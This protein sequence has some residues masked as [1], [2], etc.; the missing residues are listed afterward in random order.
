MHSLHREA[1]TVQLNGGTTG[2]TESLRLKRLTPSFKLHTI[3]KG[4]PYRHLDRRL[5]MSASQ[6]SP[7]QA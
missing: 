2:I 4:S 6:N 1:S 7:D 5:I 3:V